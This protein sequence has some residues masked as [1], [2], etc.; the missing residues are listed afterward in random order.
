MSIFSFYCW[1]D[2]LQKLG[3]LL[4]GC[5]TCEKISESYSQEMIG[6]VLLDYLLKLSIYPLSSV[7]EYKNQVLFFVLGEPLSTWN[8]SVP[9]KNDIFFETL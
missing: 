6:L 4:G 9:R 3:I 2:V 7:T 5:L 8:E 1:W